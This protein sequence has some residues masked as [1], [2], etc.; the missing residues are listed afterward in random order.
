MTTCTAFMP[1]GGANRAEFFHAEQARDDGGLYLILQ[2]LVPRGTETRAEFLRS[3]YR[4]IVGRYLSPSR[5][6]TALTFL[7]RVVRILDDTAR[8]VDTRVDDFRGLGVFVMIRERATVHL[9]CG[10]DVPARVRI[11]GAMLPVS[12]GT[13]GV[14]EVGIETTRAQQDLFAQTLTESL[15]LYRYDL[16][17]APEGG[18]EF[19]LGGSPDDAAAVLDA[20]EVE[21]G[22]NDRRVTIERCMNTVLRVVCVAPAGGAPARETEAVERAGGKTVPRAALSVA[23]VVVVVAVLAWTVG[24]RLRGGKVEGEA[25]R[26][27]QERPAPQETR[28]ESPAVSEE[29]AAVTRDS[30]PP[31]AGSSFVESWRRSY[32][33]AVTSSPAAAGGAVVF[34]ARD[35]NVYALDRKSGERLWVHRASGGVG[36]S[37]VV[38]GDAV[39]A[40]DYA[41]NVFRL[42]SKDGRVAWKRPLAEK[43]VSTPAA[44]ADRVVAGT[45]RGNVYALSLE[46]GRV[47]WKFRTSGQ[48]RG[49]IAASGGTVYVPSHD[50]KLYALAEDTGA[51]RWQVALGGPVGSSPAVSG[52]RVFV[53]T[54][55]GAVVALSADSGEK[56]WSFTT[57][58]AVNA[59]IHV[60]GDR[61]FTGSGDGNLYCLDASDGSLI[62]KHA[63]SGAI[64]ARPSV[65]NGRVVVTSYDGAVYCLDA[66][67][68]RLEDRFDTAKAIY[69]SPLVL[70]SRVYFGNNDGHFFGLEL[71]R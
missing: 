25:A 52:D 71:P 66:G 45:V 10:R 8:Q 34:G 39:I 50:G 51:R 61:V 22:R 49:S 16:A 46:T 5:P 6:E 30:P 58:G 9:L 24:P 7:R 44:S 37:P 42:G 57:G 55:R 19:L 17:S 38:A 29:L 32:R 26:A 47:L 48:I 65:E 2:D 12:A 62:W 27:S 20:L 4:E 21:R 33:D 23:G 68:G 28:G 56:A 60:A 3:A 18:I 41:G 14:T 35:G 40:C 43:I 69:S 70:G 67:S 1:E 15:A 54:A 59:A 53:G 64:F 36:A 63:T 31:Q 13:A 11:A